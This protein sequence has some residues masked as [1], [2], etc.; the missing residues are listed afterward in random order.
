MEG[1]RMPPA[2]ETKPA[3]GWGRERAKTSDAWSRPARITAVTTAGLALLTAGCG[4]DG[5]GI[6]DRPGELV[7]VS[8]AVDTVVSSERLE[9][10]LTVRVENASG[11]V[12]P[13][14]TV[15]F[16]VSAGPGSVDP[17]TATTDGSGEARTHY[18][19]PD[20]SGNARIQA[21]LPEAPAVE[22][23]TFD[24]EIVPPG[25]VRLGRAGGDDQ[26]AEPG[27]QLPEAFEVR[28]VA[29]D[30]DSA[31]GVRVVWTI[32]EEPTVAV[33]AAARLT[34]D[35]VF[36]D[37]EGRGRTLLT[38]A[39]AEGE[40]RV[41]AVLP[42]QGDTVRFTASASEEATGGIA[43]DSVRPEPLEA[44]GSA[45]LF[46]SGFGDSAS[47]LTVTVEGEEA[48]I[49]SVADDQMEVEVPTFDGRCLP[50]RS[51]GLRVRD[52]DRLSNGLTA[53]LRPSRS[54]LEMSVGEVRTLRAAEDVRCLQLVEADSDREYRIQ[55]QSGARTVTR[56]PMRLIVR[57]GPESGAT[58]NLR[59]VGRRREAAFA[60]HGPA[61]RASIRELE[62][63]RNVR[64]EL[65]RVGAR[66][67]RQGAVRLEERVQAAHQDGPPAVGDT[68]G[69]NFYVRE[70]L[71]VTCTDT[72]R[73]IGA[74][75][76]AVGQR[77]VLAEDTLA[78][79]VSG[80][81]D[82]DYAELRDEFDEAIFAVDSAY[83]GS[84]T[85]I[86][87]NERVIVLISPEVN[88]LTAEASN[89]L[90][91]GFFNSADLADSGDDAGD[92][93]T[94]GGTCATSNEGEILYLLAPDPNG[95]W[96]PD[97]S[98]ESALRS[99]R[100]TS[101]HEHQ[102]LLNA[103]T[104]LIEEGGGFEDLLDTWLDEGLSHVAEEAVGLR[105]LGEGP[106]Q[107]LT[108][109]EADGGSA[110]FDAF[111]LQNFL[112]LGIH[113]QNPS[114]TRALSASDPG[115][116][117]SLEMRGFAWG[118]LR[119][120]A[121]TRV[122]DGS[123]GFLGGPAEEELFRALARG[124]P[125]LLTG[126][127]NVLR[128]VEQVS[129]ERASWEALV[130]EFAPVAHVD[131]DVSGVPARFTYPSWHLRDVL[132]EVSQRTNRFSGYPL[133]ITEAGFETT[134]FD[135][136][137]RG[138]AQAYFLFSASGD[139][140]PLSLQLSSRMGGPVPASAVPQITVV[141]VR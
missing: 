89:T 35:T 138:S 90:I 124:G 78:R 71:T 62:L 32:V 65:R 133:R 11:R 125:A 67:V 21:S 84:P 129:G 42:D 48:S 103:G 8:A 81:T 139:A 20:A 131:D 77:V 44:G 50:A 93:T 134:G 16:A 140:P 108:H 141:R 111:F 24:V 46:G 87:H 3:P 80:F 97:V 102:H 82:A 70:N 7:R 26:A 29:G 121:D 38:L 113:Y 14:E 41:R 66:P 28:T 114:D 53:P 43:V 127:D 86:D 120:L 115:G 52:D 59:V 118:F 83:F 30:N 107:N 22:P 47:E 92:G 72:L 13:G 33:G 74:E 94:V 110:D 23:V 130:S 15:A 122:P 55:V 4:G 123:G 79:E 105:L 56:T 69:I 12:L 60:D 9:A 49:A 99:V 137:V 54:P 45:T 116:N 104:R 10:P 128:A 61:A 39:E 91:T 126:V 106:R 100:G 88:M 2:G 68:L 37:A 19:A 96:G 112:R 136:E 63:K 109:S 98:R 17:D 57:S 132:P 36:T 95:R 18:T 101:A 34:A 27:S 75:A 119:W 31:G 1:D 25:L 85:D 135:F 51:V 64:E 76:R 58:A 117:E 40:H 73:R 6:E 5:T